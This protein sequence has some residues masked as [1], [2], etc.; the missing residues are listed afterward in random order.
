M[1]LTVQNVHT[2]DTFVSPSMLTNDTTRKIIQTIMP[3]YPKGCRCITGYQDDEV[4]YWKVNYHWEYVLM[5]IDRALA[6]LDRP[7]VNEPFGKMWSGL[8]L[9]LPSTNPPNPYVGKLKIMRQQLMANAPSPLKGYKDSATEGSPKDSSSRE[10]ITQRWELLKATK[11]QFASI[12]AA[13]K[14]KTGSS[15]KDKPWQL[16]V[17]AVKKPGTSMHGQGWTLDIEGTGLNQQIVDISRALGATTAYDEESHVH[18][19]FAKGVKLPK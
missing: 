15:S 10:R 6:T 16:A 13:A 17:A 1:P 12:I 19:E 4:Q 14:L 7:P 2:W 8:A 11:I 3:Y 5:M 9:N 18:V